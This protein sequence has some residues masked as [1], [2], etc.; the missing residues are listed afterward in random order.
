MVVLT[1]VDAVDIDEVVSVA[2]VSVLV[3]MPGQMYWS[4]LLGLAVA[5]V[6]VE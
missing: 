5:P 2:E 4:R 1:V 3:K 6:A